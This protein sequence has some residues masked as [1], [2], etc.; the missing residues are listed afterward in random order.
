MFVLLSVCPLVPGPSA[1]LK[2]E[3]E[4]WVGP[5]VVQGS[6]LDPCGSERVL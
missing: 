1:R 2:M 4:V 5:V 3:L 6:G